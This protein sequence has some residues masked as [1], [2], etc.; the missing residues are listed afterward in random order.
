VSYADLTFQDRNPIKR[1]LQHRRLVT[2]ADLA[3]SRLKAPRLVCDFG[4][5]NGELCKLLA[6]RYEEARFACYEPAAYLLAEARENLKAVS[7]VEFHQDI[8]ELERGAFDLV[9][10]LE[11]F[12]HLPPEETIEALRTISALLKPGGT[13][14][15][16]VPVEIGLPALYKGVFRMSRRYGAFDATPKNVATSLLGRPP[17]NRPIAEL[18]PGLRFHY[19]HLGFDFRNLR[20]LLDR[21]FRSIEVSA[22]PLS[23]VGTWLMPEVYFVGAKPVD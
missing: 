15:I 19:E 13:V 20:R 16:G 18:A 6:A 11:V 2:A 12:E 8:R 23:A 22:S 4:A 10:C 7:R 17:Q 21:Y 1:W 3:G 14:I 5:G 9:V